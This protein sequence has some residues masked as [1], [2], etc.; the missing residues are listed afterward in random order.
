[1]FRRRIYAQGFTI[2]AMVGGSYWYADE[3]AA[4]HKYEAKAREVQQREKNRAWIKELE[5]REEERV[6]IEKAA[7]RKRE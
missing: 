4:R 5:A 1:M 7:G 3:H 2:V 6:E